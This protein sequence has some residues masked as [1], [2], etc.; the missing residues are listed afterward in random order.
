MHTR[1]S[2]HLI[3]EKIQTKTQNLFILFFWKLYHLDNWSF[4]YIFSYTVKFN[5]FEQKI[6]RNILRKNQTYKKILSFF[7][8]EFYIGSYMKTKCI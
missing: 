1:M 6:S 7:L 5:I 4:K 8:V 2:L 3:F